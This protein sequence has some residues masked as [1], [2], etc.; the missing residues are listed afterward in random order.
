MMWDES[1]CL[2]FRD[3]FSLFRSHLALPCRAFT[4]RR[5]AAAVGTSER[6]IASWLDLGSAISTRTYYCGCITSSTT[7]LPPFSVLMILCTGP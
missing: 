4:F 3:S 5:F 7:T 2:R 6:N 1:L